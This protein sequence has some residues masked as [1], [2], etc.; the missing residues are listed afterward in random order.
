M[1]PEV[2]RQAVMR[3]FPKLET[4]ARWDATRFRRLRRK[5][6]SDA[7][8]ALYYCG[9][10]F[11]PKRVAEGTPQLHLC[12]SA[13]TGEVRFDNDDLQVWVCGLRELR[14]IVNRGIGRWERW[15][16]YSYVRL[17]AE[18]TVL[19]FPSHRTRFG[20]ELAFAARTF[21]VYHCEALREV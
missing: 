5:R 20:R 16:C 10:Y 7:T 4:R 13:I 19:V 11:E 18:G 2:A 17:D 1:R 8:T 12:R 15:T 6:P 3:V 9:R 14:L 21:G